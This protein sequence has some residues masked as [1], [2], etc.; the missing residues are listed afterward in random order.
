M[1]ERQATNFRISSYTEDHRRAMIIL[2]Q[3]GVRSLAEWEFP[4]WNE[5]RGNG[6]LRSYTADIVVVDPRYFN[7]ILEIEGEGSAS[8][9][10]EKRDR[11]FERLGLWVNHLE[12]EKVGKDEILAVPGSHKI[13]DKYS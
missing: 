4:R 9:D 8:K 6:T 11:Y 13:D 7:G 5:Y 12:N 2:T 1:S 10:N 3:L